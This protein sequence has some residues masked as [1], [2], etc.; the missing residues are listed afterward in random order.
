ARLGA[1]LVERMCGRDPALQRLA[2]A[3]AAEV[4]G[5]RPNGPFYWSC[6]AER[7]VEHLVEHHL[8]CPALSGRGRLDAAAL[9]RLNELIHALLHESF[10]VEALAHIAGQSRFHFSRIFSRSVGM[11]PHRYVMQLRLERARALLGER[12]LPL[13]DVAQRTGFTDQSHL[14]R[15]SLRIYAISP[16]N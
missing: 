7:I 14:T 15:W 12:R 9:R 10:G 3:L 13:S 11:S 4:A 1:H 2:Q 16:G 5:G 8:S 6:V